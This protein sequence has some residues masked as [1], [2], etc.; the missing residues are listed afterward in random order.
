MKLKI[1]ACL[2]MSINLKAS[3][4]FVYHVHGQIVEIPTI[5]IVIGSVTLQRPM[6]PP[7]NIIQETLQQH[8]EEKL[9]Q[10]F[11]STQSG[12]IRRSS[13]SCDVELKQELEGNRAQQ[14]EERLENQRRLHQ[15]VQR[16]I[17][18]IARKKYLEKLQ[19]ALDVQVAVSSAPAIDRLSTQARC[20]QYK[21][22]LDKV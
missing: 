14:V 1:A 12:P 16:D 7:K 10:P 5:S 3:Q 19:Q 17:Y 21:N 13:L 4:S 20:A 9:R 18:D 15:K 2:L 6:T 11:R 8:Q 22:V